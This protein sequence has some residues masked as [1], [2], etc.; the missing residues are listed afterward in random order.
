MVLREQLGPLSLLL[1]AWQK[2]TSGQMESSTLLQREGERENSRDRLFLPNWSKRFTRPR[3]RSPCTMCR[4]WFELRQSRR[5][6][7]SHEIEAQAFDA[8]TE[9]CFPNRKMEICFIFWLDFQFL[10]STHMTVCTNWSKN[11][12]TLIKLYS[13]YFSISTWSTVHLIY[14]PSKAIHYFP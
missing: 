9:C 8:C 10:I 2:F 13:V 5:K 1:T 4:R 7:Q 12:V 3:A 11:T 14:L 6:F